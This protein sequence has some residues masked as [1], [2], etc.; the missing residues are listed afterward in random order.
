VR[1]ADGGVIAVFSGD[2]TRPNIIRDL[3]DVYLFSTIV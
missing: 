1:A 3:M 2:Q